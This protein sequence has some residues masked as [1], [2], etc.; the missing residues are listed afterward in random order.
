M[1]SPPYFKGAHC[2]EG[3]RSEML[4]PHLPRGPCSRATVLLDFLDGGAA[5]TRH[6]YS[7]AG[8]PTNQ[9]VPNCG[10][11]SVCGAGVSAAMPKE[12]RR[13]IAKKAALARWLREGV[14]GKI[15][16]L[17]QKSR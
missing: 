13:E 4:T 12:Q 5:V 6:L 9:A 8:W 17:P 1:I 14:A 15:L 11:V 16:L 7:A 10:R 3:G 2:F